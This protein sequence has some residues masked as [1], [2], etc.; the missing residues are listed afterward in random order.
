MVVIHDHA[1]LQAKQ[2]QKTAARKS[3]SEKPRDINEECWKVIKSIPAS[4]AGV[5]LNMAVATSSTLAMY[6]ASYMDLTIGSHIELP[7]EATTI[8]TLVFTIITVSIFDVFFFPMWEK[9]VGRSMK[10]MQ[11]GGT[12]R[13]LTVIGMIGLAAVE[14]ARL[15]R[16]SRVV[17]HYRSCGYSF[18]WYIPGGLTILF[19][20]FP[21]SLKCFSTALPT[22]PIGIGFYL[23]KAHINVVKGG[24]TWL[25]TDINTGSLDRVYWILAMIVAINFGYY[26]I[27]AVYYRYYNYPDPND[28]ESSVTVPGSTKA[29]Q[30]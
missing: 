17:K 18:R 19:Q 25:P 23:S 12:D 14:M 3:W 2:I 4:S 8:V 13:V 27:C 7:P 22:L 30:V 20:E 11:R 26:L 29:I 9:L 28:P 6:Q 24:T 10:P 21:D 15:E 5:I 1:D 16:P